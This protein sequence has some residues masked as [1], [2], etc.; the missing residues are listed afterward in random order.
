VK[1]LGTIKSKLAE[2]CGERLKICGSKCDTTQ[3]SAVVA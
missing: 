1:M 2:S 3:L